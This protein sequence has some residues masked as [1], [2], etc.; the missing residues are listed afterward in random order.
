MAFFRRNSLGPLLVAMALAL[1][2]GFGLA[3][4]L[5]ATDDMRS[6][7]DLFSQVLYLVQNNY[8]EAPDN[9]KLIKGAIDGMLKTLD[10][11]TVFVPMQRAQRMDE[12]FSGEYSGI[13]INFDLLDGA[14]V[15]IAPLEGSPSSRLGIQAGDRIV[16]IEGK[17]LQPNITNDDVFKLLRGPAGTIVN[18]KIERD[19]TPEPM[20]FAI[21]RAK[22]PLESVPY[23]FMIRPGVGY[24]R[25]TRFAQTTGNELEKALTSL[26]QQGMKSLLLDLRQNAG[27]LLS[28][29]VEVLDELVPQNKRV[30][31]TRGRIA[32]A[33]ADYYSSER[34]KLMDGPIV[35]LIDHGSASASEIVAGAMQ[36]LDRGLVAGVNSF[37]KGLVQNQLRLSDGSKL[38]LTIAKYH[39]PAGREIQRPYD[40]FSDRGEYAEDAMREDVP[41]D[42]VLAARPRFKTAAGRNVYGGG[43]IY[44]DVV[45]KEGP[46]LTRPQVELIQKRVFFEF[47]TH[48]I[49]AR[50]AEKWTP[51]AVGREFKLT[52]ADWQE[53]RAV[54]QKRKATVS[55]SVWTADREFMTQQVRAEI[56]AAAMNQTERYKILIEDDPQLLQAL[57]LFPQAS[58]LMSMAATGDGLKQVSPPGMREGDASAA[59]PG[60]GKNRKR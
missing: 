16:E 15:V 60:T 57:E 51:Q 5:Q 33:N 55:D 8:V 53:L 10:P 39:T 4:G 28:Q 38:L 59:G 23:S 27:G 48:H 42:S 24:V 9:Q 32:S 13:G 44:P 30:V 11:H 31:Y 6:Q 17:A 58:K 56:A 41:N 35:V 43:G 14:I 46:L 20:A 45:V 54:A 25:I 19:G 21:E 34:P 3:R 29:A 12:E 50:R 18:V 37:G 26:R 7:L 47:A 22:I 2:L 1:L 52:D 49:A 36:D 40:K